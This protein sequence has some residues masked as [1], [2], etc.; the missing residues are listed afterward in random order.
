MD[1]TIERRIALKGSYNFRDVGGYRTV[2]G[3][4]VRWRRLFRADQLN[5]LTDD[6]VRVVRALGVRTLIDLRT[7]EELV[8]TGHGLLHAA[9]GTVHLHVPFKEMTVTDPAEIARMR[10]L[11]KLYL[12]ML[13]GAEACINQIFTLL[14]TVETLPA[15]VHCAAGKDRTGI[16]VAVILRALGVDDQTILDDYALT[17]GYLAEHI[18][19]LRAAG[20]GDFYDQIDPS[21]LRALPETLHAMDERYGSVTG[22]LAHAGVSP[23]T[24]DE[25]R[26]NL[27]D[28]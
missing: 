5:R 9:D 26:R 7:S 13:D 20:M 6:D 25:M 23:S 27:L 24:V 8:R 16:T 12:N 3:Y 22:Y 2:D 11:P 4:E 19:Q 10:D 18:A 1:V 28:A 15:V 17:D 14:A 21:L